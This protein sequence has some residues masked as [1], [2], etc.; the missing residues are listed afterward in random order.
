M[1]ENDRAVHVLSVFPH[2]DTASGGA[3]VIAGSSLLVTTAQASAHDYVRGDRWE[4]QLSWQR[5]WGPPQRV[6][7]DMGGYVPAG[8]AGAG[9]L[10]SVGHP[11]GR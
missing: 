3:A 1:D 7:V 10:S 2:L 9:R 6:V 5:G 11:S 4:R 8:S